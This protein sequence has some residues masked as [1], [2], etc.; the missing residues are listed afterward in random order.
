MGRLKIKKAFTLIELL[1]VVAIITILAAIAVPNFL[2]AQTRSKVSRL[3]TDIRSIV[4]AMET[5]RV[6]NNRHLNPAWP[7]PEPTNSA[8]TGGHLKML[9]R[10]GTIARMI[11]SQLTTPV[12]YISDIPYDPFWAGVAAHHF[13]SIKDLAVLLSYDLTHTAIFGYTRPAIRREQYEGWWFTSPG[14]NQSV[15]AHDRSTIYDPT[16]GTI[17]NGDIHWVGGIGFV[18]GKGNTYVGYDQ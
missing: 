3:M 10:D 11:G 1:I 15:W 16:N 18:G 9:L 6:D 7:E 5:Y 2:E 4:V 8:G 14:P 17:S 12:S 13:E